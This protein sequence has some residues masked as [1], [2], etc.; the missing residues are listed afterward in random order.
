MS[1]NLLTTAEAA[2]RLGVCKSTIH[3]YVRA[4]R[5][6]IAARIGHLHLF[7]PASLRQVKRPL[8]GWPNG[9]PRNV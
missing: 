1:P 3:N 6:K 8:I 7:T 9:K 4:G 2:E 5:L